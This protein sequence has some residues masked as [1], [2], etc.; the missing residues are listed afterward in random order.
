MIAAII[1][2]II[3]SLTFTEGLLPGRKSGGASLYIIP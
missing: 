3:K 1:R 2:L